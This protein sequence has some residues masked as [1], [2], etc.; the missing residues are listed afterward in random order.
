M[1]YDNSSNFKKKQKKQKNLEIKKEILD[2]INPPK[3]NLNEDE[4]EEEEEKE[5]VEEK[6][7]E[8]KNKE[9]AKKEEKKKEESKKEEEK[10]ESI[11]DLHISIDSEE[12]LESNRKRIKHKKGHIKRLPMLVDT[13]RGA[14]EKFQEEQRLKRIRNKEE[15]R[16][17]REKIKKYFYEINRL[18]KLSDDAFDEYIREQL[19]KIKR[20]KGEANDEIIRINSFIYQVITDLAKDKNRKQKFNYL[21]P[22]SFKDKIIVDE[23]NENESYESDVDDNNVLITTTCLKKYK[24]KKEEDN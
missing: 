15:A 17:E 8:E 4:V 1:I 10:E 18:R 2:L 24:N 11:N 14:F 7:E 12:E 22:V 23:E 5:E 3:L 20:K 6:E 19:E 21:S 13:S 9:E 16:L